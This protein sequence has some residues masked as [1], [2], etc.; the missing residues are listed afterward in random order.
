MPICCYCQTKQQA[1]ENKQLRLLSLLVLCAPKISQSRSHPSVPGKGHPFHCC[2]NV[3]LCLAPC[4]AVGRLACVRA[5]VLA[6]SSVCVLAAHSQPLLRFNSRF[7]AFGQRVCARRWLCYALPAGCCIGIFCL[8]FMLTMSTHSHHTYTHSFVCAFS[9]TLTLSCCTDKLIR[10][11]DKRAR[12]FGVQRLAV[13][14]N[15]NILSLYFLAAALVAAFYRFRIF[16]WSHPLLPMNSLLTVLHIFFGWKSKS[17]SL[18]LPPPHSRVA[19][20]R[21]VSSAT[22]V[23][24]FLLPANPVPVWVVVIVVSAT[25]SSNSSGSTIPFRR[26]IHLLA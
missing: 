25:S 20:V 10:A 11:P 9:C 24:P 21:V 16:C 12:S 8:H 26:H 18:T 6:L 15:F 2:H 3:V 22:V 1:T 23:S 7:L 4:R 5:C 17:M 14:S 13:C 19:G